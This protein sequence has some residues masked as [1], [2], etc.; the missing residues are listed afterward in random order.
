MKINTKKI[1]IIW[2]ILIT[3]WLFYK[4]TGFFV[5]QP[6]GA[7][8]KWIT[9]WYWRYDTN[10]PFISSP[11]SIANFAIWGVSLLGRGIA[12]SSIT[13]LIEDKI[14]TRFSY[15]EF[16]YLQSTNGVTYWG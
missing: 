14:I 4:L 6:I 11:D 15:S 12:L 16:L 5:V 3:I 8:P 13:S 2:I 9:V 7:I 10:M 1:I